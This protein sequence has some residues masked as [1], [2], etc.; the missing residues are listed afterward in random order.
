MSMTEHDA[1]VT[2]LDGSHAWLD[3]SDDGGC[4]SCSQSGGCG[5]RAQRKH[6]RVLNDIGARVGQ[7]V[8]VSVRTG[9]V[10]RAALWS[11]MVPLA[12]MLVGAASGLTLA[13]DPGA[14]AGTVLGLVAALAV[15]R[16]VDARFGD[17][18]EPLASMRIKDVVVQLQGNPRV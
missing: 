5:K 17:A 11:Y 12:L 18:R 13:G 1:V 6:Q 9:T 3:V 4:A 7:R 2:R 10:L 16:M 8:V 15:L 14:A